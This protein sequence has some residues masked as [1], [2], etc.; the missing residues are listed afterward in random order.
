MRVTVVRPGDIGTAEAELWWKFQH[1]TPEGLNP[2]LSLTYAQTVGRYRDNARVA[3]VEDGEEI[4]A[5]FPFELAARRV[6]MPIGFPMNNLQGFISSG[7]PVSARRVVKRA[8]LRGWRFDAVPVDQ[9]AFAPFHYEGTTEP[10]PV[11]D[12]TKGDLSYISTR[13]KARRALEQAFGT[14][15]LE[16]NSAEPAYVDQMIEWKS[17]KYYGATRL[18]SDPTARSIVKDLAV[19]NGEDCR[20][21]V[22]VLRAGERP[23]AIHFALLGPRSLAGWFMAYDLELSRFAPGKML[24]HPLANAAEERG[25]SQIDLGPGRETYKLGLSNGSYMVAGGAIWVSRAEDA[26]RN[27]YRRFVYPRFR[28][29]SNSRK[30]LFFKG[31]RVGGRSL[32]DA[33]AEGS[34]SIVVSVEVGLE[35]EFAA[36]EQLAHIRHVLG[37]VRVASVQSPLGEAQRLAMGRGEGHHTVEAGKIRIA[38][39][40]AGTARRVGG[41][42]FLG[43]RL[44][45]RAVLVVFVYSHDVH[46][47]VP[48]IPSAQG[49]VNGAR[50]R[51]PDEQEVSAS[52]RAH[53]G[54]L[55]VIA[56]R[57]VAH[58]RLR[59]ADEVGLPSAVGFNAEADDHTSRPVRDEVLGQCRGVLVVVAGGARLLP[60][61]RVL[62]V[63]D[64][65]R[66]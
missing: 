26:A 23:A 16:W 61:Q 38:L 37:V 65:L 4:V 18:F 44:P 66:D 31:L 52:H 28:S 13:K 46:I 54:D 15:S 56:L 40:A 59:R 6:G 17:S 14:V 10:C 22:S 1:S 49:Q 48:W 9:H 19:S 27:A 30:A 24:W 64:G 51:V 33:G 34:Y 5:F 45:I 32:G 35:G 55:V 57:P 47:G 2:F 41:P 8:H 43:H 25:I 58:L 60:G 53:S 3:V 50:I 21:V 11:I 42:A 20:G 12:L 63:R 62:V 7:L 29:W 36:V 39:G